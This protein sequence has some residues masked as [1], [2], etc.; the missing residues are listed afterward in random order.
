M[1]PQKFSE[2]VSNWEKEI[3]AWQ[4]LAEDIDK[5]KL[6]TN[7]HYLERKTYYLGKRLVPTVFTECV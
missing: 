1:P 4:R 2:L 6:P 5:E 3:A 7:L